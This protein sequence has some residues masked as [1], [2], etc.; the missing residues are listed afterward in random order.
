MAVLLDR[1]THSVDIAER[2]EERQRLREHASDETAAAAPWRVT[3]AGPV[4]PR[5]NRLEWP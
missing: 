3:S 1:R 2:S 5:A 4:R